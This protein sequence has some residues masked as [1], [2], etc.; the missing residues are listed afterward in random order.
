MCQYKRSRTGSE[1]G[2]VGLGVGFGVGRKVGARDTVGAEEIV[3]AEERFYSGQ[4]IAMSNNGANLAVG[5]VR[6]SDSNGFIVQRV[7]VFSISN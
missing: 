4:R 2:S 6:Y 1:R 3:G 7:R 5:S